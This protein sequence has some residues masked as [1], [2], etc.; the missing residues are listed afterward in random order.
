[1]PVDLKGAVAVAIDAISDLFGSQGITNVL[2]EEIEPSGAGQWKVTIGFDR[3]ADASDSPA[4]SL[5]QGLM[6]LARRG[7]KYKVVLVDR[8]TGEVDA[9]RDRQFE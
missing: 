4:V 6:A 9:V 7:R 1:M 8:E 2:L 3:P 5:S